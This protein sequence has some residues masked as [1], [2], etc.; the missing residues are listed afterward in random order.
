MPDTKTNRGTSTVPPAHPAATVILLRPQGNELEVLLLLRAKAVKFAGGSWVF[1]GGR[2]DREDYGDNPHD[3]ESA[4]RAASA[5][6]S[7]EEAG[8][9]LNPDDFEF[10]SHWTTPIVEKKRFSTWFLWGHLQQDQQITVDD[11]E[12][13]DYLWVTPEKALRMMEQRE[14]KIMP[15]TYL[16][17]LELS[18]CRAID[19]VAALT[20]GRDMPRYF[21]N[22]VLESKTPGILLEGD[23]GYESGKME[24]NG[25][26][27]RVVMG[28]KG[29]H[30]ID[31][32]T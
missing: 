5:R 24:H 2:I 6:E 28:Q 15:P 13:V 22:L 9:S 21:P 14:L 29:W 23:E 25:I 4:A 32:R 7:H 11:S 30:Y 17:L 27:R 18:K 31:E 10:F 1:P 19:Q 26:K 3:E 8:L 20:S 16:T 12:I